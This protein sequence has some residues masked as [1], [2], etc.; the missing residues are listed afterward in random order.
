M[1]NKERKANG[2]PYHYDDPSLMGNQFEYQDKLYEYNHTRPTEQKRRKKLLKKMFAEIGEDCHVEI[3]LN[4]NW[5]GH[6]VHFGRGIYCNSNVTFVD[7]EHIYIGDYSMI[8]PNVVISTSGHPVLPILRENHYVYNLPVRIG[9]N[10]WIGS[11]V[12]IN[13]GVTIG[14]NS[15]IGAGS[16]VTNN[17][18]A[19]VV[20]FGVPCRV[21][22][23]IGEKDKKYFYKDR[24]LDVWE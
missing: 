17:I 7:D 6:H 2:L 14:D 1:N 4:A 10:V 21:I 12:Q 22:R 11:G 18:P 24:E 9:R 20:A 16:V 23:E 19:N 8:A 13:P 3:P 5:G 15:V